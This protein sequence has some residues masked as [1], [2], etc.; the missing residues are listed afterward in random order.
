M[1]LAGALLVIGLVIPAYA[2]EVLRGRVVSIDPEG[3]TIV[4]NT[5]EG[6]KTVVF[7]ETTE[8]FKTVKPGMNVEMTCIDA[9]GKSCAKIIKPLYPVKSV[10][11]EVVSIDPAGKTVVIKTVKGEEVAVETAT[12]EVEM[13]KPA[14]DAAGTEEMLEV[15]KMPVSQMKP[16][17]RVKMDCFDSGEKFCANRITAVS[18]D[19][20]GKPVQGAR[21]ITGEVVSIDPAGKA[22]VVKTVTGEK[23]LYYQKVTTG[24]GLDEVQVGKNVRAYCLDIEGKSCIKDINV[25][26]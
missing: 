12:D 10:E 2:D 24:P 3:K 9:E 17:T 5:T 11:G 19:E 4:I 13:V 25:A 21:E 15:E 7:Q 1:L 20:A 8:G 23:T 14:A 16:G 26:E 18:L 6:E 22:V